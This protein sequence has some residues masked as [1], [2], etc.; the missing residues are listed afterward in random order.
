MGRNAMAKLSFP[1][2]A[3]RPKEWI[4]ALIP[5]HLG[6][7]FVL[8]TVAVFGIGIAMLWFFAWLPSSEVP[9]TVIPE[10]IQ[11]FSEEELD[12]LVGV[13]EARTEA[14]TAPVAPPGRDP[15]R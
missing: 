5:E 13:L 15:F 12:R 8:A 4:G 10:R 1:K 6:D 9:P 2:I 11:V 14:S 7:L 3:V